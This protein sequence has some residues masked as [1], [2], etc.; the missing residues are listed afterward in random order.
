MN[1]DKNRLV[2]AM[3]RGHGL[4][5]RRPQPTAPLT[6]LGTKSRTFCDSPCVYVS[7]DNIHKSCTGFPEDVPR[8]CR[9]RFQ[10]PSG[11]CCN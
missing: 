9:I 3:S 7:S 10:M 6:A 2:A 5:G 4:R 8:I 1:S 11:F